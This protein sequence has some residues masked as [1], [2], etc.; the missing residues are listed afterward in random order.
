MGHSWSWGLGGGG[1]MS[2]AACPRLVREAFAPITLRKRQTPEQE[3]L[4]AT[5]RG[6]VGA[7]A[8]VP[9]PISTRH[10]HP[11]PASCSPNLRGRTRAEGP[12]RKLS[13][14]RLAV[15]PGLCAHS[16]TARGM[17]RGPQGFILLDLE[18]LERVTSRQLLVLTDRNVVPNAVP[19]PELGVRLPEGRRGG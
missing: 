2:M 12:R 10:P 3:D 16:H 4:G 13:S 17:T 14:G 11:H 7:E 18:D 15:H 1:Q 6:L 19:P 8:V 5:S 9:S